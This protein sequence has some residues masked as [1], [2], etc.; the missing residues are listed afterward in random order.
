MV[1][2]IEMLKEKKKKKKPVPR[3]LCLE[4]LFF[5]IEVEIKSFPNKQN[6]RV[7]HH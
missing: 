6:V 3:I 4:K 5:R 7:H 1:R 2:Y